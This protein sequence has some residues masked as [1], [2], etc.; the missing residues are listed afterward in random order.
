V[1]RFPNGYREAH[2]IGDNDVAP[3]ARLEQ[4]GKLDFIDDDVR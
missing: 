2:P 3:L 1:L 4:A